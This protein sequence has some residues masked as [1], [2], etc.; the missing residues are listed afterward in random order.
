MLVK[1]VKIGY[2]KGFPQN[3]STAPIGN[4]YSIDHQRLAAGER[5]CVGVLGG[6]LG[7]HFG[8]GSGLLARE[9]P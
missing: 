3:L 8:T 1:A 5:P 9:G 6:P 4:L 7:R 2:R